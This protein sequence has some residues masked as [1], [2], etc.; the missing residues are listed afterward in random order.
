[1]SCLR[2]PQK[3]YASLIFGRGLRQRIQGVICSFSINFIQLQLTNHV[4]VEYLLT[5]RCHR[6]QILWKGSY[7]LTMSESSFQKMQEQKAVK[8]FFLLIFEGNQYL[9]F[10]SH[11][12]FLK[13]EIRRG[14]EK[15][16]QLLMGWWWPW[17]FLSFKDLVLESLSK[18]EIG[19]WVSKETRL[20]RVWLWLGNVV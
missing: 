2:H 13:K 1:M 8:C 15:N 12:C 9:S 6:R 11:L 17:I 4:H 20:I 19:L 16:K 10:L 3:D 14:E 5:L 18:A 7:L